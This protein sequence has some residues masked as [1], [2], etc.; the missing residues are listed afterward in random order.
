MKNWLFL[1]ILLA[2]GVLQ[3]TVMGYFQIFGTMPDLLLVGVVI[4]SLIFDLRLALLCGLL[5]GVF[6]D[7][8]G[9]NTFGINALIFVSWSFLI[10]EVSR[11]L[12]INT[13][14][15]RM[16]L[17]FIVALMHNLLNGLALAFLG[18]SIPLGI[19]LRVIFI[20]SIYT[21]LALPAVFGITELS[22]E[23]KDE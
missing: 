4:A 21:A 3:V 6:K 17:I 1:F 2:L 22:L 14:S 5:A 12:S 8:L 20:S 7:S 11:R 15:R 23:I 9:L 10:A 19:F 18:K 13:N 16:V